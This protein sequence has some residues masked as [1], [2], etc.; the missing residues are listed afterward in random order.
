MSEMIITRDNYEKEVLQ[1]DLPVL[2]DFWA[3]WCGPC[4]MLAPVVA[5]IAKK[6]DGRLKVGKVN[7]DEENELAN[8]FHV[9]AIPMLA[10]MEKGKMTHTSVGFRPM[11]QLED[12]LQ[13]K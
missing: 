10:V 3:D 11:E 9:D 5:E 13:L 4:R 1:S 8:A 12:L 2:L 7:V 6:Y